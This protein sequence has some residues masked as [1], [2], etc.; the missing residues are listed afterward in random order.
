MGETGD[1]TKA[2]F[3]DHRD[4]PRLA[5]LPDLGAQGSF[6]A[7]GYLPDDRRGGVRLHPRAVRLWQVDAALH[8]RWL[9]QSDQR[10]GEDEGTG[11][12][13][14]GAGSRAGIPG[15]RAVSMEDRAGQCDVWPAPAGRASRRGRSTEPRPDRDGRAQGLRE[16]LSEGAVG[17]HEA[18]R[19]AGPD[20]RLP[21]RGPVDG[22]A[23]RCARCSYPDA[24][25]ERSPEYLGA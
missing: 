10:R 22:R 11:D 3:C 8:R 16:L 13:G 21:S 25:A 14:A 7:I 17:R 12:H 18:A 20:A 4:R 15:V 1:V 6:G 24:P 9:R 2:G 5:G 23:V 19:R